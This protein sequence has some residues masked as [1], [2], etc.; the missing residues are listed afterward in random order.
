[1]SMAD[2]F[3][4]VWRQYQAQDQQAQ[5]TQYTLMKEEKRI[6]KGESSIQGSPQKGTFLKGKQQEL[7]EGSPQGRSDQDN[8][9]DETAKSCG[10]S[11]QTLPVL[12]LAVACSWQFLL[13]SMGGNKAQATLDSSEFWH[14]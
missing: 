9:G 2:V 13:R 6:R 14:T 4:M 3:R 5:S 12:I 1:M 7:G 10:Y 11:S 8:S